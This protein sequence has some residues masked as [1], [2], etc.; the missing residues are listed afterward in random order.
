[1][2]L[3]ISRTFFQNH[4]VKNSDIIESMPDILERIISGDK[5]ATREFYTAYSPR[6]L[7]YL[8]KRLPSF[9]DSQE[10]MQDVFLEAIESLSIFKRKATVLNWLYKIARNKTV[11]YYRKKR[12][13]V[14]LLSSMPFLEIVAHEINEPEFQFEKTKIRE[15]IEKTFSLLSEKYRKILILHYEHGLRIK[16]IANMLN[17]SAKT[18]ESLLFRARRQFILAYART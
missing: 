13:K 16:E 11:D 8:T 4:S 12:V 15:K 6:I 9:E 5:T 10:I 2:A 14:L 1:M 3:Y 7:G 17:L 18:T